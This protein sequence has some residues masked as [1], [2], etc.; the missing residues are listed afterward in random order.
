MRYNALTN[1]KLK[2]DKLAADVL[3]YTQR[4]AEAIKKIPAP[5]GIAVFI[6]TK[7]ITKKPSKAVLRAK[8]MLASMADQLN[9][10]DAAADRASRKKRFRKA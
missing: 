1:T 7:A 5:E 8:E 4:C 6:T 9:K 2:I 10:A 3:L